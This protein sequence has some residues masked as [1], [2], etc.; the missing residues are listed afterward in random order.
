MKT[1]SKRFNIL[2]LSFGLLLGAYA[3]FLPAI[4]VGFPVTD[5]GLFYVMTRAIQSNHYSLPA[6]VRYNG[7]LIPFAYPPLGF[8]L[9]ALVSDVFKIPLIEVFRWLP[10]LCGVAF[11]I[12]FYP[13]ALSIL[14]SPFKASLAT[15]FFALLPRSISWYVMG[16]GITRSLGY[17]FLLLT[18]FSV[19]K[20]FTEPSKK[21]LWMSAVF[22]AGV[23]LSHPEA[24]LHTVALCFMLW[25]FYGRSITG[26]KNALLAALGTL[27]LSAPFFVVSIS[28]YGLA[29]Y[30]S[31]A[32]TGF[33]SW[34]S[35]AAILTGS[36]ADEKFVALISALALLGLAIILI[37]KDYILAVWLFLPAII[38]P[39]S[40]ASISIMPWAMLAAIGFVDAVIPGLSAQNMQPNES[41]A[42]V[43]FLKNPTIR[44]VLTGLIFYAFF[45]AVLSDQVYPKISLSKSDRDTMR[46][47]AEHVPADSRFAILTGQSEPFADAFSEWFPAL[48][49]SDSA[50]TIQGYEWLGGGAF[51]TRMKNYGALQACLSATYPCV[52]DWSAKTGQRYDYLLIKG[53]EQNSLLA[54]LAG[55]PR[56]Q[57]IYQKEDIFIFELTR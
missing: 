57:L 37:K 20:L 21:Y 3:R 50:A 39:R 55:A 14:K 54:S 44:L 56:Y 31:A 16:G 11:S 33:Q 52:D 28:R 22:G 27:A 48:A 9:T 24:A 7:V 5:G 53:G 42:T 30:Q 17:I 43:V 4:M 1:E 49:K 40:A 32:Q 25:L 36:F 15:V 18:L 35:W 2:I 46:W 45:G 12:A 29:P 34:L 10:A 47:V 38:N 8:Y 6:F 26:A 13:L 41:E 23:S 51:K 19:H